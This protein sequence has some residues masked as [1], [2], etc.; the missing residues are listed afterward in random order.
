MRRVASTTSAGCRLARRCDAAVTCVGDGARAGRGLR[1]PGVVRSRERR[2]EGLADARPA[3]RRGLVD[4]QVAADDRQAAVAALHPHVGGAVGVDDPCRSRGT[5][6]PATVAGAPG[7][8]AARR[9]RAAG[10]SAAGWAPAAAQATRWRGPRPAD[11]TAPRLRVRM[12]WSLSSM[13][14]DEST[15]AR[16][17]PRSRRSRDGRDRRFVHCTNLQPWSVG[18]VQ[19]EEVLETDG[20]A[21]AVPD[22]AQPRQH[23]RGERGPVQRVVP[24]RQRLPRRRRGSPPGGPPARGSAGRAPGSR[25][26]PRRGR[27]PARSW[28]RRAPG[29]SPASRRAAAI[30][31]AVRRAVPD[32]ASALSGWCSSTTST[33]S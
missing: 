19:V 23:A 24:D 30:S 32:G 11:A 27:P 13:R 31:S 21:R 20:E 5:S 18:S 29:A 15:S 2:L 26:R 14:R 3:R 16:P 10:G 17:C 1:R 22:R 4:D 28:S 7:C 12:S 8:A 6:G 33:D 25:R 9:R